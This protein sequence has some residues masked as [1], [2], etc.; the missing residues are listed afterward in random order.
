MKIVG[1]SMSL[2][3]RAFI[4]LSCNNFSLTRYLNKSFSIVSGT[5]GISLPNH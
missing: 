2:L 3:P 1:S 4:Q 5:N